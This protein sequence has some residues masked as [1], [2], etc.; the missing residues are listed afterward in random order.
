MTLTAE[1][2]GLNALAD[3]DPSDA[4]DMLD[5]STFQCVSFSLNKE[6]FAFPVDRVQ[7]IIRVPSTVKVPMTP[8]ALIGLTNLRGVVLPIVDLRRAIGLEEVT[9]DDAS[10]VMVIHASDTF[11]LVVDR[12]AQVLNVPQDKVE[13]AD[14]VEKTMHTDL[15]KGV[16]KNFGNEELIQLIDPD[17]VLARHFPPAEEGRASHL[18]SAMAAA[19]TAPEGETEDDV[20][21]LVSVTLDD[22]E[23]AFNL[24]EVDEIVRVPAQIARV[25]GTSSEVIGLINLRNRLLPLV[26]LRECFGLEA[27]PQ[28]DSNRVVILR[29]QD[30]DGGEMRIG[31]VVDRVREVL[32]VS[33]SVQDKVPAGMNR[34]RRDEIEAICK[35]EEGKRLVSV[36]SPAALFDGVSIK[37]ALAQAA[38]QDGSNADTDE[39]DMA[40]DNSEAEEIQMVV[41]N[42]DGEDYGVD[43]H[44]V[45]EIIRVPERLV[46]VPRAPATVEGVINLRG[47]VLPVVEMRRRFGLDTIERNDRQR[48]LVLNVN[49]TR[50]GYIVDSVTEVLRVPNSALDVPPRLSEE[51]DRLVG[52]V[53]NFDGGNRMVLVLEAAALLADE[54][55][56][57]DLTDT[58]PSELAAE[59][60]S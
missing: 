13:P 59:A 47:M 26:S 52:R 9:Y 53:A 24:G 16:I 55:I 10:R 2:P 48:I 25:P 7:E 60:A 29:M 6:T 11:G 19:Q 28:S 1:D 8:P 58:M 17:T 5:N 45:Q 18:A 27:Q 39:D 38:E 3:T 31:V 41:Y 51:A 35:L 43:I 49:D 56:P 12:V 36:L 4:P 30:Q 37:E 34:D 46:K 40:Q 14:A 15:L 57:E 21:Q 44:Q 23:Y 22:E 32:R 50:T 42:L 33:S 20:V 54:N